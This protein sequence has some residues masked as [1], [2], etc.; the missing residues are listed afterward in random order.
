M[1]NFINSGV[2]VAYTNDDTGATA[3]SAG[4]GVLIGTAGVF[5]VAMDDIGV[6]NSGTLMTEGLFELPKDGGSRKVGAKC[7]W[8]NTAKKVTSTAGSN[9]RIGWCETKCEI[10]HKTIR[11]KLGPAVL[12]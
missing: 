2:H 4:D 1:K 8:D 11:I 7:Y 10:A 3:I 9:L 5:G 12:T 6:N